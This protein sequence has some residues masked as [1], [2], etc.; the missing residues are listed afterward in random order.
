M[1]SED[2]RELDERCRQKTCIDRHGCV[3]VDSVIVAVFPGPIYHCSS[4]YGT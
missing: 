3:D 1:K 4:A 2:I